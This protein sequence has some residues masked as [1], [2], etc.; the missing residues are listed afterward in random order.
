MHDCFDFRS[1]LH[2]HAHTKENT[3]FWS[4]LA[5]SGYSGIL[6]P[7]SKVPQVI[8][9]KWAGG[10]GVRF[11]PLLTAWHYKWYVIEVNYVHHYCND[12]A[13]LAAP[14]SSGLN[15]QCRLPRCAEQFSELQLVY[16]MRTKREPN[17]TVYLWRVVKCLLLHVIQ[18]RH[19]ENVMYVYSWRNITRV[20]ENEQ[21][22]GT[23][24]LKHL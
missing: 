23:V 2:V 10:W 22:E 4:D 16:C 1:Y 18:H 7:H 6:E 24:G 9:E 14:T 17:V 11:E 21:R 15:L 5:N 8:F 12:W 13:T 3:K 19:Y 20:K